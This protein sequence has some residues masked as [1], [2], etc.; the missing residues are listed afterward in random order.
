[1]D[2]LFDKLGLK[3][4]N[5]I[6]VLN[7]PETY[8]ALLCKL[9][10]TVA[11]KPAGSYAFVQFFVHSWAEAQQ[12]VPIAYAAV[13]RGGHLWLCYP[14]GTSKKFTCDFNRD[15]AWGLFSAYDYAPV[16][17]VAID[18]DWSALR[19]KHVEDIAKKTSKR[20]ISDGS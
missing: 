6:L 17:Q 5:P 10:I 3:R 8:R 18:A 14:K 7:A 20:S 1:M 9:A 13:E 12:V 19:F 16:T 11:E 4:Q 15:S 2:K